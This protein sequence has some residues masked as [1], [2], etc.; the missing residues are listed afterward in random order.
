MGRTLLILAAFT[1]AV[2]LLRP[3]GQRQVDGLRGWPWLAVGLTL[4]VLWVR[5]FSTHGA[6]PTP[7]NW[8][9][10]VA[11]LLAL[12]FVW[13]NRRYRGLWILAAGAG[14]NLLVMVWN[15][16]LMPIAPSVLHAL[17]GPHSVAGAT[18]ALSKDRLLGDGAVHLAFLDDR[19]VWAI[20]GLHIAS[21]LGDLLVVLGCL[22]TVGEELWVSAGAPW[23]RAH[24]ER[25]TW[26]ALQELLPSLR[27]PVEQSPRE[28]MTC[29]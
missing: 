22:A 21:S 20:A 26:P 24:M 18:L 11:L 1:A 13:L 2:L 15:G 3:R 8:L 27:R 14:L 4:Q 5:G 25:G 10:S 19:L 9:P 16:G 7:F 23:V 17:G 6:S 29:R 12:R 28:D